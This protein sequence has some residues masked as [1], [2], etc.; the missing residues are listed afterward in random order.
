MQTSSNYPDVSVHCC[1][2]KHTVASSRTLL[3]D[4]VSYFMRRSASRSSE[5]AVLTFVRQKIGMM[6]YGIWR[7]TSTILDLGTSW[8]WVVSFTPRP[9]YTR[10]KCT[11]YPW[12]GAWVGPRAGLDAVEQRKISW[13]RPS[14]PY[15]VTIPTE[16][17]RRN[18]TET[19]NKQERCCRHKILQMC[20]GDSKFL[21]WAIYWLW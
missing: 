16:L 6:T 10:G 20:S 12:I 9:L 15:P 17:S 19:N 7:Y 2:G 11:Q 13:P 14:S 1:H 5:R 21:S 4:F 8:R 3:S 18:E